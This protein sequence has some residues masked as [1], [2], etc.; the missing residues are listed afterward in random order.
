MERA[1]DEEV[2]SAAQRAAPPAGEAV[3]NPSAVHA[4]H[5]DFVWLTLQRFGV[6]AVALEDAF[7]DVFIVVHRQLASFDWACPL[8]TWLFA[9][10]RRVAST[11]RRRAD[12]ERG[13]HADLGEEMK[14]PGST[15]EEILADR[16][17]EARLERLLDAIDL[18]RRAV[19]VMFELEEMPCA[20][21]AAIVGVPVGTVYSRLYAARRELAKLVER[22]R[23]LAARGGAR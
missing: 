9:V 10:C 21:I 6:P 18:D 17:A 15:P 4:E 13:R 23:A 12:R 19:F 7:Q 11:Y 1:L 20:E 22:E 14:D 5:A 3:A 16:E 8:T 2:L